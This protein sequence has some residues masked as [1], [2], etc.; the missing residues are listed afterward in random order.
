MRVDQKKEEKKDITE[1]RL[2][3]RRDGART[4]FSLTAAALVDFRSFLPSDLVPS[5]IVIESPGQAVG[6]YSYEISSGY[7]WS[8]AL[9]RLEQ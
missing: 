9:G 8:N 2:R 3:H 1:A 6:Q 4:W 5:P 7:I